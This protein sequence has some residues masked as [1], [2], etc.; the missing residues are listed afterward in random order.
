MLCLNRLHTTRATTDSTTAAATG[1]AN[2]NVQQAKLYAAAV[3]VP[4]QQKAQLYTRPPAYV[5]T[6]SMPMHASQA[7]LLV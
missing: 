3:P 6:L 2:V 7:D 5:A 1:Q 4:A